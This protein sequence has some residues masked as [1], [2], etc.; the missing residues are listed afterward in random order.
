MTISYSSISTQVQAGTTT[1]LYRAPAT[2]A[3]GDIIIWAVANKYPPNGPA[4]PTGLTSLADI[5]ASSGG[6]AGADTGNVSLNL[7]YRVSDGTEDGAT[8]TVNVTSGNSVQSRSLSYTRT[9][10]SGWDVA[11]ASFEQTTASNSW[12]G[13]TGS[14][15]LAAGDVIVFVVAQ[16]GDI[17][18]THSAHSISASG[19]TFGSFT[20]RQAATG[21]TQGDDCAL[22]LW[23]V[24]VTAG[25]GT[26]GVTV[27]F[28]LSG[29]A[30][31]TAGL[32]ALVRLRESGSGPTP[33]SFSGTVPTLTG[34][35]GSA[36]SQSLTSYFSGSLTPFTYSLQSGTLP[37]G[38][39]LS[40]GGTISG[41]PTVGGTYSGLVVRATD[42]GSNT[43]DTNS[44]QI[45]LSSSPS[46]DVGY[47]GVA[48]SSNAAQQHTTASHSFFHD[49][50]WWTFMKSGSDWN[51]YEETGNVP[52]SPGGTV[53]FVSSPHISSVHTAGQCTVCVDSA[54]NKAYVLGFSTSASTTVFRVLSYSAGAWTVTQSFNLTGTGGVGLGTAS[55]FSNHGKLSIGVDPNGVP[56]VVAGNK[57]TGASATNGVHIAWPDSAGSLGGTWSF[58][59][60]DSGPAT[61]GDSSGRFAGV[62]SQGGTSYI[63]LVYSDDSTNKIKLAYHAVETTLSNYSSGWTTVD[64]DATLSVDNH[65]WGGVMSY[66]GEQVV[67]TLMKCGDG[68]GFGRL[69]AFT[70]QLGSGLT[71]THKRHRITNGQGEAGALQE[72][73]SRPV[74]VLDQINGE[75]YAFFHVHDSY[76][77]EWIGYKKATLAALLAAANDTAV[78]DISV[79]EN[80]TPA[81]NDESLDSVSDVK[82]PAHP[83]TTG[84]GR[85]PITALVTSASTTGDSIWWNSYTVEAATFT[86]S[87][88][89]GSY[90][91]TGFDASLNASFVLAST[92][93]SYVIT[94]SDAS[95]IASLTLTS[96]PGSYAITGSD[97]ELVYTP[98]GSFELVVTP[99]VYNLTGFDATLDVTS[100]NKELIATPGFY[101]ITG[102]E[103][104]LLYSGEVSTRGGTSYATLRQLQLQRLRQELKYLYEEEDDEEVKEAALDLLEDDEVDVKAL[105][106]L[107]S[108]IRRQL[109]FVQQ[110]TLTEKVNYNRVVEATEQVK[111]MVKRRKQEEAAVAF[112]L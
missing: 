35:Q 59:T 101:T 102:F 22:A 73:P 72:T 9:G 21:T 110:Q 41:T 38:L 24:P 26:G 60:I 107:L 54:N 48:Q 42:T 88:T 43:A 97:A 82:T 100:P 96:T 11:Y 103:V 109:E 89:P 4:T 76:P 67:V 20:S 3:S 99:G 40:S 69:Y 27:S 68:T 2:L 30:G 51:L 23:E 25:S 90:T 106:G 56:Y 62:F 108:L 7:F 39:S 77:Y 8:E 29:A 64:I 31:T 91:L 104:T 16:N 1:V 45:S 49:G 44:F 58:K 55:T 53:D 19:V 47:Y 36:F 52:G 74:G 83:I 17:D 87:S 78:F 63:A 57:G 86:L 94:G 70:S 32:V 84:M 12:S 10:G 5:E 14:L 92:P 111:K 85:F 13:T 65:V 34:A 33:V 75:V 46:S 93:G 37:A 112:L 61:E 71:W 28:T 50:S 105:D 98:A 18:L 80:S 15:D 6:A 66:G 81:I 79:G 95:L